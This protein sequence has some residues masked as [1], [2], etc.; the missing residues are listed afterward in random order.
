[1]TSQMWL[2]ETFVEPDEVFHDRL[3][4]EVGG[5]R[6][7]PDHRRGETDDQCYVSV[8]GRRMVASA[9]HY[10][11]FIPNAGNG[12]RV[13]RY[14]EEWAVALREM[15]ALEPVALLPAHGEPLLDEATIQENLRI[16]AEFLEHIAAYT[17]DALNDGKRQD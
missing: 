2:N 4:L 14:I 5:E 12:K 13:Q 7:D 6:F 9:D 8:P 17:I 3:T 10:Q 16:H 1:M 15:A 11:G